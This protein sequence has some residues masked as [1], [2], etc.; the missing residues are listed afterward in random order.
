VNDLDFVLLC[1]KHAPL[2]LRVSVCVS[3]SLVRLTVIQL[4]ENVAVNLLCVCMRV[5][6]WLWQ[7]VSNNV[8]SMLR[9]VIEW[10]VQ[11]IVDRVANWIIQRGGWVSRIN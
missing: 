2:L 7:A 5:S 4:F 6:V 11:F 1:F 8:L 3:R 9:S 10:I